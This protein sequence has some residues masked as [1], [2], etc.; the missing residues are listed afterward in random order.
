MSDFSKD[1][2]YKEAKLTALDEPRLVPITTEQLVFY[3]LDINTAMLT[4]QLKKVYIL[5]KLVKRMLIYIV[6]LNLQTDLK[7]IEPISNL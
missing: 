5:Y 3:N 2:I 6:S 4:F 1:G 7:Q